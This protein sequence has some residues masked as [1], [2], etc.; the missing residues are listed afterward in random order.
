MATF[1]TTSFSAFIDRPGVFAAV[2]AKFQRVFGRTGGYGRQIMKRGMR[3]RKTASKGG[4]YPHSHQG[5]LR[6]GIFFNYDKNAKELVIG[7]L[8]FGRQ[9]RWL[10][11]GIETV[12]ELINEG[13]TYT[14][15]LRGVQRV[16]NYPAR[17]FVLLT[18]PPTVAKFKELTASIP[19]KR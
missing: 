7:P 11:A 18:K 14:R 3:K 17:P 6:D 15:T 2:D 9:P 8:R 12:P 10:P 13:G 4:G 5:G 19:L 16:F 1:L